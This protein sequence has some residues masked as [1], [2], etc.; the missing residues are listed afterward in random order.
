MK[1]CIE[2]DLRRRIKKLFMLMQ[3]FLLESK[4]KF[5]RYFNVLFSPI[6]GSSMALRLYA[7]A[8]FF[9]FSVLVSC[10]TNTRK[11]KQLENINH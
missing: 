9:R 7:L 1:L 4:Y 3:N 11:F 5:I 6:F 2:T 10:H 8:F